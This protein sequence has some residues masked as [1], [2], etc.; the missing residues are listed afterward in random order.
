[1]SIIRE[2]KETKIISFIGM[3][4]CD[5]LYYISDY[6]IKQGKKVLVVDNSFS[7]DMYKAFTTIEDGVFVEIGDLMVVK[8]I[9]YNENFYSKFDYVFVY[10]GMNLE[11]ESYEKSDYLYVMTNYMPVQVEKIKEIPLDK[12]RVHHMIFRD[13]VLKKITEDYI[14]ETIGI[15]AG[16]TYVLNVE[17]KDVELYM[18]IVYDSFRKLVG[19]SQ[20]MYDMLLKAGMEIYDIEEKQMRKIMRK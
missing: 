2:E 6:G 20:E 17:P 4:Q 10:H 16:D 11:K 14:V 7:N 8:D 15:Q 13:K 3:E 9:Q 18:L 1:M 12:D 19:C 5:I